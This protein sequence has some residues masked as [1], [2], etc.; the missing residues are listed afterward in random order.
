MGKLVMIDSQIFIWGIKGMASEGQEF[1]IGPAQRFIQF[2][3][4]EKSKLLLPVPQMAELLSCV[5]P[6]Q[7]V[8]IKRFFDK[9]FQ[10]R[11]FDELAAE[12]CAELLYHSFN[13]QELIEYRNEH[14]VPKQKIKYDC[15]LVAMAITN[16]VSKIYSDDKDLKKFAAGQID[17]VKMPDIAPAPVQQTLQFDGDPD[18][19][20]RRAEHSAVPA[21]EGE[22]GKGIV[23]EQRLDRFM[24]E[25]AG[26]PI[27]S[28]NLRFGGDQVPPQA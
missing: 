13:D 12:K 21:T 3:D 17:V 20:R 19:W 6:D 2:L 4:D 10:V 1:R 22:P 27:V 24:S 7:Q 8:E 11:P 5:P 28:G 18:T 26:K 25:I 14:K 9:R 23:I 16:R 15:M